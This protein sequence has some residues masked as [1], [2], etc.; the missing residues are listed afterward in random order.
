MGDRTSQFAG[1]ITL[2]LQRANDGDLDAEDEV[3]RLVYDELKKVASGVKRRKFSD[4][5]CDTTMLANDVF[6]TLIRD[7]NVTWKTRRKFFGYA[8][9]QIMR[10]LVDHARRKDTRMR[11]KSRA[12]DQTR[13]PAAQTES[14]LA[15]LEQAESRLSREREILMLD[16]ALPWLDAEHP[17]LAETVKLYYCISGSTSDA[18]EP[19]TGGVQRRVTVDELC[20]DVLHIN[21]GT[22]F[23]RLKKAR[24]LL[25]DRFQQ[26]GADG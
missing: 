25:A 19:P 23:R 11:R 4:L 2:L 16:A 18:A 15:Q 22:F 7:R 8:A 26:H 14:P 3:C 9:T 24:I 6:L 5:S 13:D 20:S 10:V 1:E 21:R 17:D 12:L